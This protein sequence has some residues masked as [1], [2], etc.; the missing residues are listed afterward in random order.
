MA[1][2]GTPSQV[3]G[4]KLPRVRS[5]LVAR[6]T[7]AV[8]L[9]SAFVAGGCSTAGGFSADQGIRVVSPRELQT[10]SVPIH[11]HWE[12]RRRPDN[13]AR[14]ALLVDRDPMPP[15]KS[16]RSLMD[17]AC[18][19]RPGCPDNTYLAQR[20]IYLTSAT[21]LSLE[22]LPIL[23]G[24]AGHA[25]LPTHNITIVMVDRRGVR[26]NGSAGF[27]EFRGRS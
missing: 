17:S 26:I 19:T 2:W 15:G 9:A 7:T 13:F 27:V 20:W 16:L 3:V 21:D 6:F 14:F 25:P 4:A 11:V 23:G 10:V 24:V 8:V 1:R 12:A 18:K 22:A 5:R